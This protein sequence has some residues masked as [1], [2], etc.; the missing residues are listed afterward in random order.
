MGKYTELLAICCAA[1]FSS[2][3]QSQALIEYKL[4][5][6]YKFLEYLV[7]SNLESSQDD[8]LMSVVVDDLH[9]TYT[10]ASELPMRPTKAPFSDKSAKECFS[11]LQE[12]VD[13]TN[14]ALNRENFAILDEMSIRDGSVV[15]VQGFIDSGNIRTVRVGLE[16]LEINLVALSVGLVSKN[17]SMMSR[18][19]EAA[20]LLDNSCYCRAAIG[21]A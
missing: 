7:T 18:R 6:N 20:L 15:I 3:V 9:K 14:S 5:T 1:E 11:M 10:E 2:E 8:E 17:L 13:R 16:K 4:L 12:L 19:M 21:N